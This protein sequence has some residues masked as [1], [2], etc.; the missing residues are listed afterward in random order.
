MQMVIFSRT[1]RQLNST[2]SFG[3]VYAKRLGSARLWRVGF[4]APP[5]R[6][7]LQIL[8]AVTINDLKKSSRPRGRVRQHARRVRSPEYAK[9]R[10]AI[11]QGEGGI[12]RG[13]IRG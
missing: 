2:Q 8:H 1:A 12:V 13:R 5:K 6:S 10:E 3:P 9:A 7:S 4:G 11:R